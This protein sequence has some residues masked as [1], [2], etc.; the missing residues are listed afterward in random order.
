MKI[1]YSSYHV[2]K[3]A[4]CISRDQI[5]NKNNQRK[6]IRGGFDGWL[7]YEK[8]LNCDYGDQFTILIGKSDASIVSIVVSRLSFDVYFVDDVIINGRSV[9]LGKD[10]LAFFTTERKKELQDYLGV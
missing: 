7:C 6:M 5:L 2:P 9:L 4:T 10:K 1:P 8:D 3:V